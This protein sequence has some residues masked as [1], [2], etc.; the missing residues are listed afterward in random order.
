MSKDVMFLAVGCV[1]VFASLEV[2]PFDVFF[3]CY[4]SIESPPP[5][6]VRTWH[7][8]AT[9]QRRRAISFWSCIFGPVLI[10]MTRLYARHP[11]MQDLFSENFAAGGP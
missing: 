11:G 5:P 9:N 4:L 7:A 10:G 8:D 3:T 2:A 6:E 1:V